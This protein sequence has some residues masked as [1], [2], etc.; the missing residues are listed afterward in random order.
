VP[1]AFAFAFAADVGVTCSKRIH[2]AVLRFV[3]AARFSIDEEGLANK[4]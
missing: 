4:T 1:F 3:S 2:C